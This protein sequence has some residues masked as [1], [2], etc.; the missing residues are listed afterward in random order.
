MNEHALD[1]FTFEIIKAKLLAIASEMS[2]VLARTSMSPIIYEVLD[3]ACGFCDADGEYDPA[4]LARLTK[5]ARRLA[6]QRTA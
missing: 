2:V 4:E 1:P 6:A 3:F 5:R